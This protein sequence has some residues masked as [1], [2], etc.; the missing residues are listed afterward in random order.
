ML[1][2]ETNK[3]DEVMAKLRQEHRAVEAPRQLELLLRAEAEQK[4]AE[5][6]GVPLN[7]L[8]A[9][10]LS[11]VLVASILLGVAAWEMHRDHR[12]EEQKVQAV[13]HVAPVPNSVQQSTPSKLTSPKRRDTL[14]PVR[15]AR[16]RPERDES[17]LEEA[18]FEDFVALPASEGLPPTSAISLVRMR[19]EQSALQQYGLEVP[20]ETEPKTLLAEFVV[21]EDGL[22]R[23]IRILP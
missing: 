7:R 1:M 8:W 14:S 12:F 21:G 13:Q 20:A 19:I 18:S 5:A 10:G 15:H 17:G 22:P 16:P 6:R 3:F 11:L 2:K 4:A 23:A 9:W